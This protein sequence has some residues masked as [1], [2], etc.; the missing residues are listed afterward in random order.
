MHP[1]VFRS[2][3]NIFQYETYISIALFIQI[4]RA[5]SDEISECFIYESNVTLDQFS[6]TFGGLNAGGKDNTAY[7]S[8]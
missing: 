1:Y 4:F 3:R 7:Y 8:L 5:S 2:I 6:Y